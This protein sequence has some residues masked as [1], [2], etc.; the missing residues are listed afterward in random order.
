M[1]GLIRPFIGG[2]A[3]VLTDISKAGFVDKLA[4]ERSD[5]DF[6][7]DKEMKR[8]TGEFSEMSDRQFE[9]AKT[10]KTI[11]AGAKDTRTTNIKNAAAMKAEGYP[12]DVADAVAYGAMKQIKDEDTGQMVMVNSLSGK[13]VGRL[14]D[15][16]WLKTGEMPPKADVTSVHRK[17]AKKAGSEKAGWTTSD[18]E[19]FPGTEGDRKQWERNE[20]QRIAN[21]ERAGG[22]SGIVSSVA[23]TQKSA[24]NQAPQGALDAV[25]NDPKLL[26]QFIDKYGYDPTKQ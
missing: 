17:K 19:D 10:D 2:A 18:E 22:K 5:A 12:E 11:A 20:A 13:E 1:G 16:G 3:N 26:K 23:G 24:Q 6:L 14:T 8:G 4:R 15:Q 25:K 21:E 7:R 9:M